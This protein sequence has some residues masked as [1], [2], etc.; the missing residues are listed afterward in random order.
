MSSRPPLLAGLRR[1]LLGAWLSC[2]YGL[3]I[4]A[5]AL[6]PAMAAAHAPL[7]D[8]VLCSGL[9]TPGQDA[10]ETGGEASH[11]KGCPVN[12]LLAAPACAGGLIA[13]RTPVRLQQVEFAGNVAPER[14]RLGLPP[15][16][17]PPRA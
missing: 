3:A 5:G 16:R 6:A 15:S 11:C 9:A 1:S 10:P 4:L 2:A 12:P 8:A 7:R 13:L 17:G 14:G